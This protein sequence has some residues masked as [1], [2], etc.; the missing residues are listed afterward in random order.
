LIFTFFQ[1]TF[2]Q[3]KTSNMIQKGHKM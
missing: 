2:C 1:E 3:L